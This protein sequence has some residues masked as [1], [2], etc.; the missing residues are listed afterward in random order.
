MPGIY[1][2]D[3]SI[4]VTV[5]DGSTITGL[6]APDGS[7]NVVVSDGVDY[8]GIYHPCGA[9]NVTVLT[10]GPEGILATDGSLFVQEAPYTYSGGF[11][12]TVV[13]GSLSGFSLDAPVLTLLTDA[14][15][16]TPLWSFELVSPLADDV[17]RIEW[18]DAIPYA[19]QVSFSDYTITAGDISTGDYDFDFGLSA[20]ANGPWSWRAYHRRGGSSSP[21]SNEVTLTIAA[22]VTA[23]TL[24]SP[25][26]ASASA[27]TGTGSVSTNEGNGTLYFVVSTSATPPSAAQVKAGQMHTGAAATDSGSQA[28]SGTGVQ[29]ITGG[30]TGLTASTT[31]YAHYMHED[32]SANQS[33]VSSG[34]GFTTAA[35]APTFERTAALNFV[36]SGT[37]HT[38]SAT[39]I[40]DASATKVLLIFAFCAGAATTASGLTVGGNAATLLTGT[41]LSSS[42]V[43]SSAF[44]IE[45]ASGDPEDIAVTWNATVSSMGIIVYALD[46]VDPTETARVSSAA[47]G[48][49]DVNTITVPTDGFAISGSLLQNS[50]AEGV[51][52]NCTEDGTRV[53][54]AGGTGVPMQSAHTTTA[55]SQSPTI[56]PTGSDIIIHHTIAFGP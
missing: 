29:S 26:D 28:V 42:G 33:S 49:S 44:K 18:D 45:I 39:D 8:A 9:Y 11:R 15:D 4:N 16:N 10:E 56:D 27:T 54:I 34:D 43:G 31:Y 3:G 5:V 14:T 50:T 12:V 7:W 41:N 22:D 20:F 2:A 47:F 37:S 55:G 23:P 21:V 19:A 30:F 17:I 1:A 40:G 24:S 52:S 35:D 32:T 13:S 6:Y 48:A 36:G 38:F 53:F 51:W 25:F 46:G